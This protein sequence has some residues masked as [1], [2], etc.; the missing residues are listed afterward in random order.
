MQFYYFLNGSCL[1]DCP[2]K[3]FPISL[4]QTCSLCTYP[5]DGCVNSTTCISCVSPFYLTSSGKCVTNCELNEY[6]MSN[7]CR[8][9]E[10]PCETCSLQL[11]NCTRCLSGFYFNSG[12]C[13]TV[14]PSPLVPASVNGNNIC[15]S[16]ISP[17]STC[18]MTSTNCTS[19]ISQFKLHQ[20]TCITTCPQ[21]FY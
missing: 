5:C 3:Y 19:C 18:A 20:E 17:C 14:C 21:S 11:N 9:C 1:T 12:S 10:I 7:V 8:R 2:S 6:A 4:N 15:T 16:C 13:L